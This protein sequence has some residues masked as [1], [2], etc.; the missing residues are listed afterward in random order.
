MAMPVENRSFTDLLS[1]TFSQ[2]GDLV[3]SEIQL[4][5]TEMLLQVSKAANAV[6]FLAAAAVLAIP[7]LVML[8]LTISAALVEAGLDEWLGNLIA[9]VIGMAASAI[10]AWI[11][12]NRI[13]AASFVPKRTL[14]QL[15]LD[16]VAAK[17]QVR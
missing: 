6:G 11:G 16:A 14:E 13:K 1:D 5:R 9:T 15:H 3:R 8:L 4:A 2:L 17:E 10:L 12:L 7:A